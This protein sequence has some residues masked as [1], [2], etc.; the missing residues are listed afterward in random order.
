MGAMT[1]QKPMVVHMGGGKSASV[2]DNGLD[3]LIEIVGSVVFTVTW[4]SQYAVL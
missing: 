1:S 4:V 3:E 2:I